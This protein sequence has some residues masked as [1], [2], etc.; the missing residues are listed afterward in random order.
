MRGNL[1]KK[2]KIKA[3]FMVMLF[4]TAFMI[5]FLPEVA[6]AEVAISIEPEVGY[7]GDTL[8]VNGTIETPNGNYTIF[9]TKNR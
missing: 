7:V 3:A 5:S 2:G 9:L 1:S 4:L 8:R 6:V